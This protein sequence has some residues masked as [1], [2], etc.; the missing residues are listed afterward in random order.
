MKFSSEE[1]WP[2]H[3]KPY[4][5]D[6]YRAA[7]ARGWT[8]ETH[9]SHTG[10]ATLTCPGGAHTLKVYATGRGAESV[11]KTHLLVIQRCGHGG[12][13]DRV[14]MARELLDRAERLLSA[15]DRLRAEAHLLVRAEKLAEDEGPWADLLELLDEAERRAS[16][17]SQLLADY[18]GELRE[19]SLVAEVDGNLGAARVELFAVAGSAE[20]RRQR[21]RL[22]E[23]KRQCDAFRS[24]FGS[25]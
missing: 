3:T 4:F 17:A 22:R 23:M 18:E 9:S 24:Q 15:L 19:A 12:D 7:R 25:D 2:D 16:E 10:A 6:V 1:Q 20:V 5:R 8:L 11:A 21:E 14:A 13:A